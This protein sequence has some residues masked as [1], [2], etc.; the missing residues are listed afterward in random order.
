MGPTESESPAAPC[1]AGAPTGPVPRAS[2]AAWCA[3]GARGRCMPCVVCC[4]LW[5]ACCMLHV[6]QLILLVACCMLS[7]CCML[8]ACCVLHNSCLHAVGCILLQIAWCMLHKPCCMLHAARCGRPELCADRAAQKCPSR[9]LR[10]RGRAARDAV[11][12]LAIPCRVGYHV[13]WD[14]MSCGIL[15]MRRN[16][17]GK[18]EP[19]R[20][21]VGLK[22]RDT[23]PTCSR[24]Y[25]SV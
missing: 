1:G 22:L 17:V 7:A 14:T 19:L 8:V 15:G 4:A 6:A 2:H 13:A 10:K 24:V 23:Y 11:S 5:D 20:L 12:V 16:G 9:A 21:R 25:L 18:G 3:R